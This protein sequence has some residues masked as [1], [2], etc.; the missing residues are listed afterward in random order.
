[1]NSSELGTR[2]KMVADMVRKGGC[3]ADIGTD[4][5]FLPSYLVLNEICEKAI[6]VDVKKGPLLN[7]KETLDAY[8]IGDRVL[9]RLS[10][11]L[12]DIKR[13]EADDIILAGMGGVMISKI[14]KR[15]EWVKDSRK[16]LIIQPQSH[17]EV[18]RKF[19]YTNGFEIM[20]EDSC[21]DEGRVYIAIHAR[22][23]GK[24]QHKEPF[25]YYVG[26]LEECNKE[27]AYKYLK[28]QY[29]RVKKRSESLLSVG[30]L[31]KEEAELSQVVKEMEKILIKIERREKYGE[32]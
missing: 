20:K 7:A 16:Q 10:D 32:R 1:M 30:R 31:P 22:Y 23:S 19:L 2:L 26:K 28:K 8:K 11:G 24:Q 6:A 27:S 15:C 13:D 9:L 3:V 25:N 29:L 21:I 17:A 18:V 5:A 4:H 12:D 14:L